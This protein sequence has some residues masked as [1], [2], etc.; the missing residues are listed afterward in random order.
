MP[1]SAI[2][3]GCISGP[4]GGVGEGEGVVGRPHRVTDFERLWAAITRKP[5]LYAFDLLEWNGTDLRRA[6]CNAA[7]EAQKRAGNSIQLCEHIGGANGEAVFHRACRIG[8]EG[9]V[10]AKRNHQ[11]RNYLI[12]TPGI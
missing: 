5:F 4:P 8:L 1:P 7:R 2:D 11:K 6:I 3:C 12:L 9:I 10:R